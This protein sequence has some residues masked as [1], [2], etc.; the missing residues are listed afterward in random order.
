MSGINDPLNWDLVRRQTY[1]A[2]KYTENTYVPMPTVTL[3]SDS[4][5]MMFG[6]RNTEA[7]SSWWLAARVSMK[8]LTLPS[9]T[10]QFLAAVDGGFS[11]GC[12]LGELTLVHFPDYKQSD[13]VVEVR[14]PTW[15]KQMYME[16][17]KY[18][19]DEI[20]PVVRI[21]VKLDSLLQ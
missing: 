1:T 2:V 21:E 5:L 19:G 16:A 8:I 9:S 20:D 3:A 4:R 15:H 7:K 10:S 14:F 12:G 6:F 18:S 17:W 13:F 11:K